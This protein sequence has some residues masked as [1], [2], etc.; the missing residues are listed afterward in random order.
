MLRKDNQDLYLPISRKIM[1]LINRVS[2]DYE[3]RNF[4]IFLF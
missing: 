1:Q 3:G 2:T 4:I